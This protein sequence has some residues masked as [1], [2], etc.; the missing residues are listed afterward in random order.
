MNWLI[1]LLLGVFVIASIFLAGVIVYGQVKL[2][3]EGGIQ[4]STKTGPLT[5]EERSR[6][7]MKRRNE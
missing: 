4:I 2:R 3:R 7:G 6:F 1:G 5:D